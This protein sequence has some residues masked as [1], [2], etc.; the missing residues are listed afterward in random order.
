LCSYD[1]TPDHLLLDVSV[2]VDG[3]TWSG[4]KSL[5]RAR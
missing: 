5:F 4:V 1:A 3:A 2:P